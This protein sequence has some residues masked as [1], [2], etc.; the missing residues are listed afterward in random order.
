VE[1]A[2]QAQ[3]QGLQAV[4]RRDDEQDVQGHRAAAAAAAPPPPHK[5]QLISRDAVAS[6]W[7]LCRNTWALIIT[8]QNLHLKVKGKSPRRLMRE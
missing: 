7:G 8:I 4:Q 2:S 5:I 1:S 3:R 6:S